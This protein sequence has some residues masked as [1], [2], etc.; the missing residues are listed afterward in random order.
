[1]AGS[2]KRANGEGTLFWEEARGRWVAELV[3]PNGERRKRTA[4]TK[5]EAGQL[6]TR[7]VIDVERTGGVFD[8]SSRFSD[9]AR[10]WRE[11]VLDAKVMAPSTRSGKDW[12]LGRLED[13]LSRVKLVHLNADRIEGALAA[14]AA[15]GLGRESLIKVRSVANQVCKFG[16][17]RDLLRRNPVSVVE[18]PAGLKESTA[19]RSLSV[20]EAHLLLA[21][22]EAD[23][24][25][26]LW[27]V[28]LM[29][30]LRPGEATGL[31]WD[32]IDFEN[33]VL[34][35][36]RGLRKVDG[37]FEVTDQ[38]KTRSSRR[39]LDMP[40]P[41]VAALRCHKESQDSERLEA[42]GAWSKRW[43]DL[44]FTTVTGTPLDSSNLRRGFS[45]L[46][47]SVGLGHW[48]PKELRH[49]AASLLSAEGVPLE[50]IGDVM[51]HES[52]RMT[53]QVYRHLVT[54]SIGAAVKPMG[55]IFG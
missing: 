38:L 1:M 2:R 18:L 5:K 8:Q 37:A 51:G 11:K 34:H 32:G 9:L 47:K 13:E 7:M 36:R 22:S 10:L 53:S 31:H 45:C 12:A 54:P 21:A 14:M 33:N 35:V 3:L 46:T 23:R 29:L 43:P 6:L 17:R 55:E 52:T 16:E 20:E 19:G 39:S 50:N 15:D 30:G 24:L 41:L 44:V 26:A 40:P 25:D 4:R 28:M 49:T 27:K 48:T 42:G